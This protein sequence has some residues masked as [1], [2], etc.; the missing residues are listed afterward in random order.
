MRETRLDLRVLQPVNDCFPLM[1]SDTDLSTIG[2]LG[3]TV[4]FRA[5]FTT[6][7]LSASAVSGVLSHQRPH[8]A[9]QRS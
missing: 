2:S 3:R 8:S 1:P 5:I 7:S 9:G 4:A 6:D